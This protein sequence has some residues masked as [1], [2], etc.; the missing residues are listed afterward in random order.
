MGRGIDMDNNVLQQNIC[1]KWAITRDEL[2]K[3][4]KHLLTNG[5]SYSGDIFALGACAELLT[6]GDI[7][8]VKQ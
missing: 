4:A 7:K 3:A 6:N 5:E 8:E 2:Y 1:T